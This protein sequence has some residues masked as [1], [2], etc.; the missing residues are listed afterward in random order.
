MGPELMESMRAQ[1]ARF[2]AELVTDDVVAVG[3]AGESRRSSTA[4]A[5][6]PGPR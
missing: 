1:A 5:D 2:G 6:L 3:L 4:R